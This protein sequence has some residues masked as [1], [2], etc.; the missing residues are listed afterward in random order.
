MAM[1]QRGKKQEG[2][3][4]MSDFNSEARVGKPWTTQI[5]TK[6]RRGSK[7][8]SWQKRKESERARER[9]KS[10]RETES[11]RKERKN[12]FHTDRNSNL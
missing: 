11:S 5:R 7:E 6:W 3:K 8:T 9:G 1:R 10:Q 2:K 12:V 4:E